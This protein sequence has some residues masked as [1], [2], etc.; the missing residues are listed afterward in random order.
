MKWGTEGEDDGQFNVPFGIAI[1]A[2]GDVFV[3]DGNNARIQVFNSSGEF[4]RKWGSFGRGEGQF[5]FPSGIA[6]D[7][8][9]NVFVVDL[10]NDRIQVFNTDGEFLMKWG[11]EGRGDYQF[12]GPHGI[13]VDASGNVYVADRGN[14]R[15]QVFSVDVPSQPSDPLPFAT[16]V[17]TSSLSTATP[18]LAPEGVQHVGAWGGTRGSGDGE[19]LGPQGV[20]VDGSGNVYVIDEGHRVQVF[21]SSGEFLFKWGALGRSDG[22]FERPNG[23]VV[24]ESGKVYVLDTSRIQVFSVELP[25][26]GDVQQ[27]TAV[28][29]TLMGVFVLIISG[30]VASGYLARKRVGTA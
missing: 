28:P 16:P 11:T 15:V 24:D 29:A 2:S 23:I 1:D 27:Q 25:S 14:G 20:A 18:V 12:S 30:L 26:P 8:S 5:D 21:T 3:A 13:T 7:T 4:L 10:G 6:I 19:L 9:G 22:E 17:A